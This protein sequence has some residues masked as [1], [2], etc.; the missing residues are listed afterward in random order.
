[1]SSRLRTE[2]SREVSEEAVAMVR[3]EVGELGPEWA[4]RVMWEDE[5]CLEV[6]VIGA[7]EGLI[8]EG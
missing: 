6:T 5:V 8:L 7:T 4:V 3:A 2:G 1:M